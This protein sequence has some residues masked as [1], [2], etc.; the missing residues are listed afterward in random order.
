MVKRTFTSK[1]KGF[2]IVEVLIA[3]LLGSLAI[4]FSAWVF[5][6]VSKSFQDSRQDYSFHTEVLQLR[7]V[8]ENDMDKATAISFDDNVLKIDLADSTVIYY[9]FYDKTLVRSINQLSDTFYLKISNINP[10]YENKASHRLN[11]FSVDVIR[12]DTTWETL[13]FFK[14]YPDILNIEEK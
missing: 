1:V 6:I 13:H 14:K 2:T 8:L 12:K 3:M 7:H 5:L 11:L 9:D 4:A 10:G